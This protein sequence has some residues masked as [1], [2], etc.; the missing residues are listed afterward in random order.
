MK[1]KDK[2]RKARGASGRANQVKEVR[3]EESKKEGP[4]LDASISFM[5]AGLH[6]LRGRRARAHGVMKVVCANALQGES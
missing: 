1:N 5:Q 2:Q 4:C 3:G 6:T